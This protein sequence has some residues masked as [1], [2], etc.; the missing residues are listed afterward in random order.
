MR[1]SRTA[2]EKARNAKG[3]QTKR[4]AAELNIGTAVIGTYTE[5]LK[6]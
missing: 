6:L 5:S 2:M 1:P 3:G 4:K